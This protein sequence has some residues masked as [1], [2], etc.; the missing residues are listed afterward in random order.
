MTLLILAKEK[1]DYYKVLGVSKGASKKEIKKAYRKLA[2]KY[3][4]DMNKSADAE[5]KFKE[6]QEAYEVLSDEQKRRAYD[7]FGHAGTSGFGGGGF[8]Q[9]S[10][11]SGFRGA[12]FS[13][14]GFDDIG[15]IFDT[16]F[17]GQQR[18]ASGRRRQKASRGSDLKM[19]IELEFKEAV[20]GTEKDITYT[21]RVNC[22]SCNGS[23]A[24]DGT[25][26]ETCHQCEGAGRVTRVQKTF[27]GSIQTTT[28]CP[29]CNGEGE[30]I[31]EKCEECNGKGR[32]NQKEKLKV[33]IPPGASDGLVLKF[34]GKGNAGSQNGAYGDLYV[35]IEVHPHELF[36]RRGDD[37]YIEKEISVLDAVLGSRIDVETLHG[38]VKV[39]VKPGTQPGSI[40]RL[41]DKGV[42][43]L[44]EKGR[45]DQYIQLRIKIPEKLSKKQK[46][47]WKKLSEEK[48]TKDNI[49]GRLFS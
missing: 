2:K 47:L 49:V 6:V 44:Q 39:K 42:P 1:K 48:N 37:I 11:G 24:K 26:K 34:K 10:D 28:V 18:R 35:Q 16:F 46:E 14:F 29:A 43:K 32:Q 13:G 31:K 9:G 21:R 5:D 27:I 33:K 19:E 20:F 7:Q 36:E 45:G 8:N 30:I 25:S 23:G 22:Q 4:P 3:H 15:S 12:D 38:E 40:M 41:R 17:G